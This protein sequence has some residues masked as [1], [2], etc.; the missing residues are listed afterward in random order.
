M[1]AKSSPRNLAAHSSRIL[2]CVQSPH[3]MMTQ[4]HGPFYT[5]KRPFGAW[6]ECHN[7]EQKD[8]FRTAANSPKCQS[9]IKH[10]PRVELGL[11]PGA[12]G[13]RQQV[14]TEMQRREYA[15]I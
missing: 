7:L 1:N 8:E 11:Q 4:W 9:R 3:F 10:S 5:M 2:R 12:Q 14:W 15:N 13:L 6:K